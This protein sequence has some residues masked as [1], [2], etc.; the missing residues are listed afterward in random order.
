MSVY[1]IRFG[2]NFS[3]KVVLQV[4]GGIVHVTILKV[5]KKIGI[6]IFK[7]TVRTAAAIGIIVVTVGTSVKTGVFALSV[8][9]TEDENVFIDRIYTEVVPYFFRSENLVRK[10]VTIF[11]SKVCITVCMNFSSCFRLQASFF[12]RKFARKFV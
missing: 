2:R 7:A 10:V 1:T 12:D 9:K 8:R 6:A 4:R 3:V 5:S 11:A